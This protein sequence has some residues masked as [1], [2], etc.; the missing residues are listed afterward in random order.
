[1][2][3]EHWRT[4]VSFQRSKWINMDQL[5]TSAFQARCVLKV[6]MSSKTTCSIVFPRKAAIP[7]I[8]PQAFRQAWLVRFNSLP[9]SSPACA[10]QRVT[11][12]HRWTGVAGATIC[13]RSA[14][15][16]A[17]VRSFKWSAEMPWIPGCRNGKKFLWKVHWWCLRPYFCE[18][19]G[20]E[21]C[22]GVLWIEMESNISILLKKI[23]RLIFIL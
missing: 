8:L 5:W 17:H 3:G 20:P 19:C 2:F 9:W 1:M 21:L 22:T 16:H 23:Y 14:S 18:R 6:I 12:R 15:F 10:A 7:H 13:H 11:T 4:T